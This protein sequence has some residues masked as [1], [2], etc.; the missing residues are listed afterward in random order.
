MK[1]SSFLHGAVLASILVMGVPAH[2]GAA[3]D[4]ETSPHGVAAAGVGPRIRCSSAPS[5]TP[6]GTGPCPGARPGALIRTDEGGCTMN[7]IFRDDNGHDYAGTAGHCT[8]SAQGEAVWNK[9]VGPLVEGGD[10]KPIGRF[11]YAVLQGPHD[12]GLIRLFRHVES[13]PEMCHFGGPTGIDSSTRSD[14]FVVQFFGNGSVIGNLGVVNQTTLPA[15][16]A[17]APEMNDRNEVVAAGVSVG[18][19][20]GAP[21]TDRDSDRAIGVLVAAQGEGIIVITRIGP[22]LAKAESAI[23]ADLTLRKAG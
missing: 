7:F 9:G 2:A 8:L 15:R 6:V 14:P 20:S 12:F 18:G 13:N 10:G 1:R 22:V 5:E 16:S 17:V 3:L 19:D 21:V 11:V 23:G 4:T